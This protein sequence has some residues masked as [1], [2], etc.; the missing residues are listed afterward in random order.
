M[1]KYIF[2]YKPIPDNLVR[3]KYM[4]LFVIDATKRSQVYIHSDLFIMKNSIFKN[5]IMKQ[6]K[7]YIKTMSKKKERKKWKK[8]MKEK[9]I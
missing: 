9:H 6:K 3:Y 1:N 8:Q 7:E 2:V 5:V 4:D